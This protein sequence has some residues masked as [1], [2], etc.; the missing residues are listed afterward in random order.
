M[1]ALT[2]GGLTLKNRAGL[3]VIACIP[4]NIYINVETA[5][6]TTDTGR[7]LVPEDRRHGNDRRVA[8]KDRRSIA[9]CTGPHC[10]SNMFLHDRRFAGDRRQA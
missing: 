1:V 4:Y 3:Y 7:K 9:R 6:V 10:K 8:T 5:E 2:T